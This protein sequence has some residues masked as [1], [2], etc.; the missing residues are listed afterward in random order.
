MV[1][2][3]DDDEPL[4]TVESQW[5]YIEVVYYWAI[6]CTQR[7]DNKSVCIPVYTLKAQETSITQEAPGGG[8]LRLQ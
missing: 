3:K 8:R 5:V 2:V 6:K 4:A 1:K 7:S